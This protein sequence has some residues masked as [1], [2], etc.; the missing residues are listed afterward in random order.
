[1][2]PRR[3]QVVALSLALLF[4]AGSI[5]FV[6]G[7]RGGSDEDPSA[8]ELGFLTDMIIHHE[9]AV[10]MSRTALSA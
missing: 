7:G 5:G 9:Q 1:M 10:S 6:I 8:A 2:S 3:G 4:L